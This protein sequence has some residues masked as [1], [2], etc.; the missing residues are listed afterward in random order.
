MINTS[1]EPVYPIYQHLLPLVERQTGKVL[2]FFLCP[3]TQFT[4]SGKQTVWQDKPPVDVSCV[5]NPK[6]F[7]RSKGRFF[8]YMAIVTDKGHFPPI[9]RE[10]F[11]P[12]KDVSVMSLWQANKAWTRHAISYGLYTGLVR[13]FFDTIREY[14]RA[15]TRNEDY[16]DPELPDD[17]D[18][19]DSETDFRGYPVKPLYVTLTVEDSNL[20]H[21]FDYLD[22]EWL[23]EYHKALVNAGFEDN[24]PLAV[25]VAETPKCFKASLFSGVMSPSGLTEGTEPTQ[26]AIPSMLRLLRLRTPSVGVYKTKLMV[27]A[28]LCSY[29][30]YIVVAV[31]PTKAVP[32]ENPLP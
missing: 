10:H 20:V 22:V 1:Q 25:E 29:A 17:S 13:G 4:F 9:S 23:A 30:F 12:A 18:T 26:S 21:E 28:P 2:G 14:E 5:T 8:Q 27:T 7:S 6:Q 15:H 16:V 19:G 3:H 11:V 24:A 32:A 31:L